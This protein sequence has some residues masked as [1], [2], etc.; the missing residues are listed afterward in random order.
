MGGP[1]LVTTEPLAGMAGDGTG[2][3][4]YV[5]VA[6]PRCGNGLWR[7]Y[8]DRLEMTLSPRGG[9]RRTISAQLHGAAWLRVICEKCNGV[10]QSHG[11]DP[12]EA[13]V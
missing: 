13:T 4:R 6:C 12:P 11:T 2:I 3:E 5:W 10:W 7:Q 1:L 8:A 9:Q